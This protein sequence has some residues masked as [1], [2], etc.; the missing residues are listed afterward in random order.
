M[1]TIV[2][3]ED[4]QI[5]V[6]VEGVAAGLARLTAAGDAEIARIADS[7]S[8]LAT[9]W[10]NSL[11]SFI[12]L[13][14][15]ITDTNSA[16]GS[17]L[18]RLRRNGS[19]MASISK[20]GAGVLAAGL[21]LGGALSAPSA[22]LGA[23]A[24]VDLLTIGGS[25][26]F[27]GSGN[28]L[29]FNS[30]FNSGWKYAGT[31]YAAAFQLA[32][33][34]TL[35]YANT[36]T[37]GSAG[38]AA[39]IANAFQIDK[40]GKVGIGITPTDKLHVSGGFTLTGTFT[41]GGGLI[42]A[43]NAGTFTIAPTIGQNLELKTASNGYVRF[44]DNT[45]GR[46][47]IIGGDRFWSTAGGNVASI[48][49]TDAAGYSALAYRDSSSDHSGTGS[50][51]LAFGYYNPVDGSGF[52]DPDNSDGG[53]FIETSNDP[54]TVG[55]TRPPTALRI[56]QSG[57]IQG[58][59]QIGVVRTDYRRDGIVR[60]RDQAGN[61]TFDLPA[62]NTAG[63]TLNTALTLAG[64]FTLTGGTVTTSSP[65]VDATQTW[66]GAGVTFTAWKLNVT[67]T[68]S[69]A[70]SILAD[71]Q[72][73]GASKTYIRKDGVIGMQSNLLI[74]NNAA[75]IYIGASSDVPL[76][77]DAANVFAR[78]NGTAAQTD[79]LYRTYTSGS[80]GA[81]L[82]FGWSSTTALM[83]TVASGGEVRGNIAF[84]SA[85][86]A[87]T[88]TAG[89]LMMPS[90]PGAS[91]GVPADIPTGQV[92]FVYDSSNNKIGVYSGGA[93]RWTAALS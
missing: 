53:N 32:S 58:S 47:V 16:S 23:T 71:F 37:S 31:G 1:T 25:V 89:Y 56:I 51:R 79:R 87:T 50:E 19:I 82:S 64:K 90:A 77:R 92:P 42:Q 86:L 15:D 91:T 54:E 59:W 11:T 44:L 3:V 10:D 88:D 61:T 13:G 38:G 36:S 93:W 34:G 81:Y 66:N 30:Y 5:V 18:M 62:L 14:L 75:G 83:Q 4:N 24:T 7:L 43:T 69:S 60:F 17:L 9:T 49:Q 76:L 52:S 35:Y 67:D 29:H 12:G 45:T 2:R 26:C 22:A 20:L 28:G 8:A 21:T 85:A 78:R 74:L 48:R 39:S 68:A 57:Y 73:G 6:S 41:T 40:D 65:A 46:A 72:V 63:A 33:D 80:Q 27:P 84:G 70:T 55:S